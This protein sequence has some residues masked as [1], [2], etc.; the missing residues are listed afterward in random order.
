[1]NYTSKRFSME[2]MEEMLQQERERCAKIAEGINPIDLNE[3]EAW[4]FVEA[5]EKIA[6]AIREGK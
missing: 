6:K 5:Q 1:M 2:Q 3:D 4:G